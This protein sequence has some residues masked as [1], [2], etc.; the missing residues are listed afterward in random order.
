M[1]INIVAVTRNKFV[2]IPKFDDANTLGI[3]K[4]ITKGFTTPPVRYISEPN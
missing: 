2:L 4:K 1:I 3:N